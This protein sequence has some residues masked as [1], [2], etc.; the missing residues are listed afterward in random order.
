V[1]AGKMQLARSH[2]PMNDVLRQSVDGMRAA[3]AHREQRLEATIP[4]VPIVVE[5]DADRLVPLRQARDAANAP[6]VSA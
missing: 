4:E 1:G 5:G 6:G 2:V 3:I